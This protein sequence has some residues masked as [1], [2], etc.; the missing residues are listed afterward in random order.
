MK[1]DIEEY[2][3]G[4]ATCQES[5]INTRPLKP[6]MIPITPK[7]SLPFHTIAM[8][9]ITKLPISGGYDMILTIT[10]HDCSKC[11]KTMVRGW[12]QLALFLG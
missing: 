4:C 11:H 8:D 1:Q 7:H 10:D 3:K 2:V 9:I 5:K 6:T 12:T